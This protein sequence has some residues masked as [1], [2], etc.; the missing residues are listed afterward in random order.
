[1]AGVSGAEQ[2]AEFADDVEDF[3]ARIPDILREA[4]EETVK[5]LRREVVKNINQD[6]TSKGGTLDSRTSPY[7]PGG[8]NDSSTDNFHISEPSAWRIVGPFNAGDEIQ[9]F[10][11]PKED[12]SDRAYYIDQGTD[13]HSPDGDNP[14]YFNYNGITI[15]V[16]DA[17]VTDEGGDTVPIS[18]RFDAE[19]QAVDGVEE[20]NYFG[21]AIATIKAENVLQEELNKAFAQAVQESF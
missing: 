5:Q 15:V 21:R 7:E 1:M 6:S 12:V 17:P 11:Q 13:S 3:K 8:E 19:P 4:T 9:A 10:L 18:E 20:M 16:S 14:Y 2:F